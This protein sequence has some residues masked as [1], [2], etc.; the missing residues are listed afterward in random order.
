MSRTYLDYAAATPLDSRVHAAMGPFLDTSF[1]NPSSSHAAGRIAR[2]AVEQ[3]RER[4]ARVIGA[5]PQEIIFTSGGTESANLALRGVAEHFRTPGHII[6]SQIEH[7]AVLDPVHALERQGWEVTYL[8]VDRFGF[9]NPATVAAAIRPETKLI[10]IGLVNNEIG[11]IQD[12]KKI[13]ALTK[14]HHILLHTDAC[15]AGLLDLTV[16]KLGV[17]LMTLNAAKIYGPKG[18]GILYVRQGVKIQPQQLGGGQERGLRSGTE[19]VPAIVGMATA[20]QLIQRDRTTRLKH[21][22]ALETK[23][24]K[25]VFATMPGIRRNGHPKYFLPGIISLTLP[26]LKADNVLAVL[27]KHGI[28]AAK[29]AACLVSRDDDSHVLTAI[30]LTPAQRQRT[31]RISLGSPT[32]AVEIAAFLKVWQH[33]GKKSRS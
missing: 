11:T 23:L 2:A 27:D 3:A 15:Q 22:R 13:S 17:D 5:Q 31:I 19:N 12:L 7:H 32:T 1:A 10:S 29:G 24:L 26:R 33:L 9:L 18:A 30:R 28:D 4:I 16:K 25:G 21:L 14:K 8:A 6:V 20:L